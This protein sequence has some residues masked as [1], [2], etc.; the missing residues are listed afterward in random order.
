L[1][2]TDR[3]I[4]CDLAQRAMNYLVYYAQPSKTTSIRTQLDALYVHRKNLNLSINMKFNFKQTYSL[5]TKQR[6]KIHHTWKRPLK[7]A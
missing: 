3:S 1:G 2:V 4:N 7:Q 6:T 5:Q